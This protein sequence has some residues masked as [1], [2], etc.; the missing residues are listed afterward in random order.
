MKRITFVR[1]AKSDWGTEFLKDIDRPLNERGYNDAYLQ[2]NWYFENHK[3][4]DRIISSTATR[5]LNTALIFARAMKLKMENFTINETIYEST[6]DIILKLIHKQDNTIT[7]LMMFGHNPGFTNISNELSDELFFD[8]L[9]TCG[10]ISFDF[11]ATKWT[12][13]KKQGGKLNFYQFPKDFKN[14][15]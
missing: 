11:D 8:N 14:K 2:S 12:D 6:S 5:A 1:H 9:P 13:I 7:H 10:M 15:D 3:V 4:P